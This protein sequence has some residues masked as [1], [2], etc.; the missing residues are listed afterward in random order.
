MI[1]INPICLIA[2]V[3]LVD[4]RQASSGVRQYIDHFE[5]EYRFDDDEFIYTGGKVIWKDIPYLIYQNY[6]IPN[7]IKFNIWFI[8]SVT[9]DIIHIPKQNP[10]T[11]ASMIHTDFQY[12]GI[13][14][15]LVNQ[16]VQIKIPLLARYKIQFESYRL[17]VVDR[18]LREYG[19]CSKTNYVLAFEA[20][21]DLYLLP[22]ESF[23]INSLLANLDWYCQWATPGR[24]LFYAWVCGLSTQLF[25]VSLLTPWLET[26]ERHGHSERYTKY[27]GEKVV[28]DDAAVYNYDK[29]FTIQNKSNYPILIKWWISGDS[30][31]MIGI[32]R[33][34]NII[35]QIQK[36]EIW[37]LEWQVI[38]KNFAS[39]SLVESGVWTTKYS[40]KNK[41]QN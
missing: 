16:G 35:T 33:Q 10:W 31:Y 5:K 1:I 23:T 26:I 39:G 20:L 36:K 24:Y 12:S 22:N 18:N 28:W 38:K 15:D 3:E 7:I 27:Y 34:S 19:K 11:M 32:T 13:I 14:Y 8:Q 41:D 2:P 9:P 21:H 37:S 17:S 40:I 29:K 6:E 30:H 4:I 25:R